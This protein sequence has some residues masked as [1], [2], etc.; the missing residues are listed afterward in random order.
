MKILRI[1]PPIYSA[2]FGALAV[3][4]LQADQPVFEELN[5]LKSTFEPLGNMV[6]AGDGYFY[7]AACWAESAMGGLIFRI[8]PGQGEEIL[9]TFGSVE[10]GG[11]PNVGGAN[12][13][14]PLVIG[15]DGAFYGCTSYGGAHGFG[16]IYRITSDG[17]FGVLHEFTVSQSG[18]GIFSIVATPQGEL[19]GVNNYGGSLSGGTI[20]KLG[21]DGVFQAV[22]GFERSPIVA[23]WEDLPEGTRFPFHSPTKLVLGPDGKLYG[24][25][26][27]GGLVYRSKPFAFSYGGMFRY[28]APDSVSIISEYSRNGEPNGSNAVLGV[29]GPDGFYGTRNH[30]LV[31]TGLDGAATILADLE[32]MGVTPGVSLIMPDGIY[33]LS[34]HGGDHQ[35]GYVFRYVQGAGAEIIHHFTENYAN[36]RRCL[37]A[38][39]DGFVYGI[40]A[41]PQGY[42]PPATTATTTLAASKAKAKG[43]K[44]KNPVTPGPITFRFKTGA[45]ASNFVPVAKPDSATL[46]LKA[47]NGKR[48]VLIDVLA[49][50]SD[51]DGDALSIT[52][53][54]ELSDGSAE[55]VSGA[56]GTSVRFTTSSSN[57]GSQLLTYQLS[58]GKGGSSTGSISIMAPASGSFSGIATSEGAADAPLT[59]TFGKNNTVTATLVLGGKKYVGKG[60]LDVDDSADLSLQAKKQPSVGLHIGL[61]RGASSS[62]SAMFMKGDAVYTATCAP[63]TGKKK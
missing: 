34:T 37:V 6:N 45:T 4:P 3:L 28:D 9:H 1:C 41:F 14:C 40:A 50:D 44:P 55:L 51:A 18:G 39:N 19:Y 26:A 33:G 20:F 7:G 11:D 48:E 13:T 16:V 25:V 59:L 5:I 8:A 23:P 54:G 46:P 43:K 38:G 22:H 15:A 21:A 53:L 58:D 24:S 29:P 12:P 52:S 35:A 57:P 62:V 56:R 36:R 63:Q 47:T 30:K 32:F 61:A 10:N 42:V 31:R 17:V 60:E 49:N 27:Q 2:L